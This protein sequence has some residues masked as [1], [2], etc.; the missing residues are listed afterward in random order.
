[1]CAL[2]LALWPLLIL[3]SDDVPCYDGVIVALP[4]QD[5]LFIAGHNEGALS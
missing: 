5:C 4:L 1:M 3:G 2:L